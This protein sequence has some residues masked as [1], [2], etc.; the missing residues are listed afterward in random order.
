MIKGEDNGETN[1]D[2]RIFGNGFVKFGRFQPLT[3]NPP[4]FRVPGELKFRCEVSSRRSE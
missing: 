2:L 1:L 3:R 4:L